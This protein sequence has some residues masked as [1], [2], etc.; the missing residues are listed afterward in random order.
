MT[1]A[2]SFKHR[3]D[4]SKFVQDLKETNTSKG[5]VTNC[6]GITVM[7]SFGKISSPKPIDEASRFH[8]SFYEISRRIMINENIRDA[9]EKTSR[10]IRKSLALR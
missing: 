4:Y 3:P 10:E 6:D 7:D 1:E 5:Y 9:G 8:K 2:K